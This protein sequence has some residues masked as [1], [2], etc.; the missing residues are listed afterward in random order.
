VRSAV[1]GT[2]STKEHIFW[3]EWDGKYFMDKGM[4]R[5]SFGLAKL[6]YR[7]PIPQ[8]RTFSVEE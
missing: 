4:I 6:L 7:V 3:G 8:K 5:V 1:P 2:F